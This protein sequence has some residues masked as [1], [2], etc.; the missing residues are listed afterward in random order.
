MV[1]QR[2][3]QAEPTWGFVYYDR[4]GPADDW[5]TEIDRKLQSVQCLVL[6]LSAGFFSS[7]RDCHKEY[8]TFLKRIR[9]ANRPDGAAALIVPVLWQ[10]PEDYQDKFGK[11][12]L[13]KAIRVW[14]DHD[15]YRQY[16][17]A[18]LKRQRPNEYGD[19][20]WKL[21]GNVVQALNSTPLPPDPR[22]NETWYDI[23][24]PTAPAPAAFAPGFLEYAPERCDR[25]T[26]TRQFKEFHAASEAKRFRGVVLTGG[27]L[28]YGTQCARRFWRLLLGQSTK[29]P[30]VDVTTSVSAEPGEDLAAT[31]LY[32]GFSISADPNSIGTSAANDAQLVAKLCAMPMVGVLLKVEVESH[33]NPLPYLQAVLAYLQKLVQRTQKETPVMVFVRV[34]VADPWGSFLRQE[35]VYKLAQRKVA[36][37]CRKL[38]R[39]VKSGTSWIDWFEEPLLMDP[40]DRNEIESWLGQV[41]LTD[42]NAKNRWFDEQA[43][44]KAGYYRMEP[45]Y[46]AM[47]TYCDDLSRM[48]VR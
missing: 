9:E 14:Q 17:L 15:G 2:L 31:D 32:S 1:Q 4:E 42:Q 48:Y 43:L 38:A 26:P 30:E 29:L 11:E 19:V 40:V 5:E 33:Q 36:A 44:G 25:T 18:Y 10:P 8:T 12:S 46:E 20:L 13:L 6:I 16:G 23:A 41:G 37:D 27:S 47:K 22:P 45:L 28:D 21:A 24:P 3:G 35:L 34:D 7:Q 39:R